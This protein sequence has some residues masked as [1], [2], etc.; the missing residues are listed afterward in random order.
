MNPHK[1]MKGVPQLGSLFAVS[2]FCLPWTMFRIGL[3]RDSAILQA[4]KVSLP[5]PW[6]LLP[7]SWV[8]PVA[9]GGY[10]MASSYRR[11]CSQ[12]ALFV[13][14]AWCM[15]MRAGLHACHTWKQSVD[16]LNERQLLF[17]PSSE[18]YHHSCCAPPL[19]PA[20]C[21]STRGHLGFMSGLSADMCTR[22]RR[23]AC[24]NAAGR[25]CT[26]AGGQ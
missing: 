13:H 5:A 18:A 16:V 17:C 15:I 20:T 25:A 9:P 11:H 26:S 24:T 23:P 1:Y 19:Q 6:V 12:H 22:V 4:T 10:I 21:G 8:L 7:A 14:D 2:S 3:L